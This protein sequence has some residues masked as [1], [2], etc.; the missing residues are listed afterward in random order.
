M[1]EQLSSRLA[2]LETTVVSDVLDEAG[3]PAQALAP[4]IRP[5]A[6]DMRLA[7]EAVCLA[8]GARV[9]TKSRPVRGAYDI[10]AAVR[11]GAVA[12][13]ATNGFTGGAVMGGFIARALQAK[14]CAGLL[15]DGCVRDA[16]E[17][18]Q[19]GFATFTRHVTPVNG[20]RRFEI[21]GVD[22][23]VALP[24]PGRGTV[25][26]QPGDLVLAD[27]DGVVV[28]PRGVAEAIIAAAEE[29]AAIEQRIDAA[30]A[31]GASRRQA[32]AAN[33]RFDHIPRLR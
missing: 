7:G 20:S 30:M 14:G 27:Y 26:V 29:L 4:K 8:G 21:A 1:T 31:S 6:P 22:E 16:R 13:L 9:A 24:G 17:I 10:E 15:T 5:L 28:V 32:F 23:P 2:R 18:I 12:V 3:F 11:P 19:I 25:L 33:P